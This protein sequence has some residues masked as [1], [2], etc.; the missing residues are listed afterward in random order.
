[1]QARIFGVLAVQENAMQELLNLTENEI[2]ALTELTKA[3]RELWPPARIKLFGSKATGT[4]D[5]ESDVDVLVLLPCPVDA[6]IRKQIIH[7]VFEINLA[8]ESNISVLIVSGEEWDS[9]VFSFLPIHSFIEQE[10]VSL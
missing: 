6:T 1:L 2:V 9:S 10:G 7:K 4:F 5:A 3:I 8:H